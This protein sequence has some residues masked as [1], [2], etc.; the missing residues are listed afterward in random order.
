MNK[1]KTILQLNKYFI[2]IGLLL[3]IYVLIFTKF[4]KYESLYTLND[5]IFTG[6]ITNYS[7]NGNKLTMEVKGK[8]KVIVNYYFKNE[9]E[10]ENLFFSLHL[11]DTISF[12]GTFKEV[13]N[14]TIPNTFNYKNYLYNKKIYYTFTATSIN[15]IDNNKNIFYIIKDTLLKKIYSRDNADYLLTFVLC[16]KS[17]LNSEDYTSFKNNGIAHLL[18]ISGMH[19]GILL[20]ILNF[21]LKKAKENMRF[22]I[23]S[24]VLLIFAFLTSFVPSILRVSLFFILNKINKEFNLRYKS[25]EI[26]L[27]TA[28]ILVLFNPFIVYDLGFIYSFVISFGIMYYQDKITGNYFNKLFRI[29]LIAFLFSLPINSLVNYEINLTSIISNMV[30]VPFISLILYPLSLITFIIPILSPLFNFILKITAYLNLIFTKF[31]LIINIPKMPIVLVILCFLLLIYLKRNKKLIICLILIIALC[32]VIP[33]LDNNY[34]VYYLDVNQGDSSLIISPHQKNVLMI[35]TGG[36]VTFN[37]DEWA[38]SSKTYQLSDNTIQFLKSIGITKINYLIL[39]HGDFDHMGEAINLVNNFKVEKVIFNCGEYN[40]LEQELIKVLDKKNIKYYSCIKEL[41]IDNNKLYFLQTKEYDNE[42]DNSNVIYT[43]L[44]G[45]KFMFMG[46][47]STT[48][49]KE[50]MNRYNLPDIDV[51]KVGHHGSKT[52]SSEY[53]INEINPKYSIISVGKNNRYGHPNTEVLENLKESKIY[54]TDED[55]SI[56]FKIKNNKLKIETCAP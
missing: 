22:T 13:S 19:V 39:T 50:I 26:L 9:E 24:I 18:A 40:D 54:R 8:E 41:N 27:I 38:K 1:L 48:T 31:V 51:L 36:K 52:S 42:N 6:K 21:C 23:I 46:D 25:I 55:G 47:A 2:I 56:M 49:E 10:K 37:Q 35:D 4:I 14:N 44:D 43:E 15:I 29:S 11:K 45:Y 33:L 28:Y 32:K 17:L 7:F 30:F 53:F 3:F 12:F 20:T 5:T 16:D 34:Y